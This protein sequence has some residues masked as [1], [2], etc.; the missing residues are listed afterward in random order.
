M[1][2]DQSYSLS[3]NIKLRYQGAYSTQ[4]LKPIGILVTDWMG[5]HTA[6]LGGEYYFVNIFVMSRRP[7]IPSSMEL[8]DRT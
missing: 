7:I 4:I 1:G 6:Y 8:K 5:L 3:G 2:M